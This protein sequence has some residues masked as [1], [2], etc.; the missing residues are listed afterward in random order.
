MNRHVHLYDNVRMLRKQGLTYA[1]INRK[2][3]VSIPKSTLSGICRGIM[4]SPTQQ[5]RIK[6]INNASLEGAQKQAVAANKKILDAKIQS[7]RDS[8]EHLLQFMQAHEAQLIALAMLYLG[9]GAKWKSHR[10][11]VL[12]NT[13]PMIV[14]TYIALLISCY[15]IA[16]EKLRAR[17]HHRSDQ[18]P[19]HLLD[20]WVNVTSIPRR[21]FY[22]CYADKRTLGR[23][24]I[25]S[26]YKGVCS[27]ICSGT[28]IQLELEQIAGIISEA[29]G[30]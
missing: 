18:N 28:Y 9:E 30:C 12:G 23:P 13:N 14:K 21:H 8:N 2:L 1:E 16:P 20:Y 22:P 26:D 19:D 3:K 17:I 10:G 5:A 27:I 15:G 25:K 6:A 24:T 11:L 7:Y 4:L 29:M